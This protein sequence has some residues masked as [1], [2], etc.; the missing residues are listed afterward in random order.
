MFMWS[1]KFGLNHC[2]FTEN[3]TVR[4]KFQWNFKH[5]AIIFINCCC[6]GIATEMS[7]WEGVVVTPSDRA[8][9]KPEEKEDDKEDGEGDEQ[10]EAEWVGGTRVGLTHCCCYLKFSNSY[11]V[12]ISWASPVSISPS[13]QSSSSTFII[14]NI[15]HHHNHHLLGNR[16][17]PSSTKPLPEPMLS[18]FYVIVWRH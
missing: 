10:M 13:S 18:Q 9:E 1:Y 17:V 7:V 2:W 16:L 8:Y 15:H 12:E 5:I 11:Q 4:N 3:F 6:A 14:I